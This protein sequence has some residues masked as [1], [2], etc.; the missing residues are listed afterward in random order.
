MNIADCIERIRPYGFLHLHHHEDETWSATVKLRINAEGAV[1]EVK[2]G[3]KHTTA[4][5]ACWT[6]LERVL[7]IVDQASDLKQI[8]DDKRITK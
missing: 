1:F 7:E 2:S 4:A 5:M 3:Y 8:S 6:V